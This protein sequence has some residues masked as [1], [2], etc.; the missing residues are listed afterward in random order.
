MSKKIPISVSWS[1]GKDATLAL[2]HILQDTQFEVIELHTLINKD[3]QRVGLH[4]IQ[5]TLI[6]QQANQLGLPVHF[7]ELNKDTSNASFEKVTGAYYQS[8][9]DRDIHHVLFGD[10]FLEDLKKYRD[11]LLSE[12]GLDGIYPLWQKDT[13]KL[14]HQFL[15]L[16]F[17][18]LICAA[19]PDKFDF[20]VAGKNYSKELL[21]QF[22]ID[23]DAC[24]ENGEFH[25]FVYDGPLYKKSLKITLGEVEVHEYQ[26]KDNQ[27]NEQTSR[28]EFV[29]VNM[30]ET[31]TSSL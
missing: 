17:Q 23:V 9:K 26:F 24:G 14:A 12:H 7:L 22:P 13:L 6:E 11:E 30:A 18:T 4:G 10:I 2:W 20:H 1:G 29:E 28:M 25:S 8:L 27:G 31:T 15:D 21:D 5:K 3:T 16:S 19:N